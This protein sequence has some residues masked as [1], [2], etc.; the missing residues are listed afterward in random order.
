MLP[1]SLNE[2]R[3]VNSLQ[4]PQQKYL[5]TGHF[6]LSLNMSLFI[7]PLRVPGKGAPS[8]FPNK[9][10][11]G[12][13]S[14]SLEPLSTFHTLILISRPTDATCGRLLLS[15][16]MIYNSTCFQRQAL[17]IR[18]LSLYIQPPVSVF[19]SVRGTVL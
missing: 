5:P 16:Y 8:M 11:M 10:P 14:P 12:S 13:D 9:V 17:I 4:V 19:V 1:F 3:L 18:S 6:Y 2:S 15:V 7:V